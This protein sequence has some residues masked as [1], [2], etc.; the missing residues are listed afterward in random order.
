MAHLGT[1]TTFVLGRE[2]YAVLRHVLLDRNTSVVDALHA[3]G[4][5]Y[6]IDFSIDDPPRLDASAAITDPPWY[7]ADT[8]AFLVATNRVCAVG[9]S[10]V[11]CQPTLATAM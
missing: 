7:P 6:Q 9:A 3:T 8:H 4:Q 10:I 5:V 11:L 2:R 1:P